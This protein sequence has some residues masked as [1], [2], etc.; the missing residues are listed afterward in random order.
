MARGSGHRA[1]ENWHN[2]ST[3]DNAKPKQ[4]PCP[5]PLCVSFLT[6]R[7]AIPVGAIPYVADYPG[8]RRSLCWYR[9][10]QNT[11]AAFLTPNKDRAESLP[12]SDRPCC[13]AIASAWERRNSG[14]NGESL[15]VERAQTPSR[16]GCPEPQ[17]CFEGKRNT[18]DKTDFDKS[19][20][21]PCHHPRPQFRPYRRYRRDETETRLAS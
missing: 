15:S 17:R 14:E 8:G 9:A 16:R 1:P 12:V 2:L 5:H 7:S 6:F 19:R 13:P 10:Q 18:G 4:P 21:D 3:E 20:A 11:P